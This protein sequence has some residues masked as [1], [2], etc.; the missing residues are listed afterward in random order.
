MYGWRGLANSCRVVPGLHEHARVHHIDALAHAGDDAQVVRDHD[1]RR[2]LL[3]DELAQ[4]VEDLRLDRHV[5]RGRR[6]VGDQD[7][8]LAGEGHGDH[9][10]LAHAPRELVRV[11]AEPL[12]RARD[13]DAVDELGGAIL[14]LALAHVEVRLDGLAEL[15][16]DGE[17]RVQARHRVLEDHRDLPAPDVPHL[18][19]GELDQVAIAEERAAGGHAT[20]PGQDPHQRQRGHALAAAGLADDPERLARGDVERDPVDGVD[21]PA[22]G[23]ELHTEVL[24]R[25]ES[26]SLGH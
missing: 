26:A 25:Q 5:E 13:A 8:R 15:A 22:R 21:R 17:H 4:Q 24:D 7:L 14:R 2:V 12:V 19:V 16:P 3:G 23:P 9:R 20:R 11:V 6:L 10:A 1:Q 18:L